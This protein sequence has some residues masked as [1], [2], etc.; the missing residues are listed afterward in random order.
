MARMK[1]KIPKTSS[2]RARFLISIL[3]SLSLSARGD[4]LSQPDDPIT[5]TFNSDHTPD[6][7]D[8][9][10]PDVGKEVE[11]QEEKPVSEM[12]EEERIAELGKPRLGEITR[13]QC[14]IMES[15]EFKV[16]RRVVIRKWNI[17]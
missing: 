5:A 13:V 16:R 17:M 7:D 9:D 6:D 11:Q 8:D 3:F 12:T 2:T 14:H 15:M 1:R 10:H 4:S